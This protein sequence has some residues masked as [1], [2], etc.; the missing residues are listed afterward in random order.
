MMLF[1]ICFCDVIHAC[2]TQLNTGPR[3]GKHGGFKDRKRLA[4]AKK[5]PPLSNEMAIRMIEQKLKHMRK[6]N[7]K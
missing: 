4:K 5:M 7:P 3:F 2:F 6:N 1:D